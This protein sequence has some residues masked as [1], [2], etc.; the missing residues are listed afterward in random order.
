MTV[1]GEYIACIFSSENGPGMFFRNVEIVL[2]D[3]VATH[4]SK[5]YSSVTPVSSMEDLRA[6][7]LSLVSVNLNREKITKFIFTEL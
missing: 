1:S 4:S 7:V 2:P 3:Y 5:Q 6:A